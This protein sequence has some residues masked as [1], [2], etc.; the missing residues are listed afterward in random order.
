LLGDEGEKHAEEDK[1]ERYGEHSE[2]TSLLG[3]NGEAEEKL[4]I[5]PREIPAL[6]CAMQS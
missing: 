1:G 6:R 2:R 5:F 4:R 3:G